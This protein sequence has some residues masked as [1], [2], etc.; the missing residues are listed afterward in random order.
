VFASDKL[1]ALEISLVNC[2]RLGKGVRKEENVW[3]IKKILQDPG[4]FQ[5]DSNRE[6]AESMP[7]IVKSWRDTGDTPCRQ[8]HREDAK[9]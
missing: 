7:L 9:L 2:L 5:D 3:F 1:T 6:E 4:L 8:N